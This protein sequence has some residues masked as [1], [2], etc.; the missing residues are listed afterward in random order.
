MIYT[1]NENSFTKKHLTKTLENKK[2][3]S[4]TNRHFLKQT[5]YLNYLVNN[6]SLY[7]V[8]VHNSL[9]TNNSNLSQ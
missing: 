6:N 7:L 3:L 8:K 5:I 2:C 1:I 4:K 9:S